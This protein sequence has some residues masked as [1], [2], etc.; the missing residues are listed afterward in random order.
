MHEIFGFDAYSPPQ[1]AVKVRDLGVTK[2]CL[3]LLTLALL[4]VLA[5]AFIGLGGLMFSLVASDASLGF[6]ASRLL[7][8]LV[9]SLGLLLVVV[10]GAELFTGNNL[11]VMAW[12]GGHVG[13]RALLRNWVVVCAANFAG[14]VGLAV[15][16]WLSGFGST[17]DG[18]VGR[19][20]VRLAVAKTQLPWI[21]AFFRAVLCNALVCMRY[22]WRWRAAAS[23]TRLSLYSSPSRPSS[24]RVSSTR[25]RTCT[26]SPWA[27]CSVLR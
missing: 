23:S 20:I 6:A 15:L 16:V 14:A 18:L 26:C 21:E 13:T 11:L 25:L 2:A 5:G 22:G 10:A 8:G 27:G 24:R 7:G 3:P 1:I 19:A 4:G 12:A 17:N 9:L